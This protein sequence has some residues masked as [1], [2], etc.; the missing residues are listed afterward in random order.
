MELLAICGEDKLG[1]RALVRGTLSQR[2]K[3]LGNLPRWA[4]LDVNIAG[5]KDAPN[6]GLVR[7]PALQVWK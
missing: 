3:C 5:L 7:M 4:G 1:L 6:V 2:R